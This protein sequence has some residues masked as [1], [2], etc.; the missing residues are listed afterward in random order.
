MSKLDVHLI[1]RISGHKGVGAFD[2]QKWTYDEAFEQ[3]FGPGRG[4]FKQRNSKKF[5]CPGVCPRGRMLKL[6]FDW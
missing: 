6:P 1:R 2:H 5:K 3:L 4:A